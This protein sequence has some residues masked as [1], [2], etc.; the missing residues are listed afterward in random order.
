MDMGM[1]GDL[2]PPEPGESKLKWLR[3]VAFKLVREQAA[4]FFA[5]GDL[6]DGAIASTVSVLAI[7]PALPW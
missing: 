7:V 4:D 6:I 3:K 1:F 2:E 5:L